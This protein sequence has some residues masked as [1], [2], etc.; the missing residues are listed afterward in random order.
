MILI[1][2][3]SY[4]ASRV[5][6]AEVNF[7]ASFLVWPVIGFVGA[8]VG[9]WLESQWLVPLGVGRSLLSLLARWSNLDK[10]VVS[11]LRG[12]R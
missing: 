6:R 9:G 5:S 12:T 4:N 2:E 10:A 1:R 7:A 11:G 3:S 8:V